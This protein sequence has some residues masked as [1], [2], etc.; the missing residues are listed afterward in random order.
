M[1]D[2]NVFE[3]LLDDKNS[4]KDVWADSAYGSAKKR[5]AIKEQ[6]FRGHIQHK[7]CRHKKLT[8]R[9]IDGNYKRSKIRSRIEHIFGVQAMR[10][11]S[12]LIRTIG[13]ARA[14]AK[15]GLRNLAYNIDRYCLLAGA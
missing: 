2:S 13:I 4:S 11:G 7:G 15:I 14:K 5:E 1:H 12:L 3:E 10:A 8:Q 9:Q 6:C